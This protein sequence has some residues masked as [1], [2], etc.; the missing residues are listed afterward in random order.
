MKNRS[1]CCIQPAL[2]LVVLV[3]QSLALSA[4]EIH[5]VPLD[6]PDGQ[7]RAEFFLNAQG[8]PG[9]R[10]SRAGRPVLI[11]SRLGLI[12]EDADFSSALIWQEPSS[13][14][15]ILDTYELPG[16]KRLVNRYEANRRVFRLA[17]AKGGRID[18]TFQVSN[19][20]VAFRY[21]FPDASA[22]I[23]RIREE[24]TSFRFDPA[25]RAWLQPIAEA[26]TSWGKCNPSY[27]EY[28]ECD[29]PVGK[30]PATGVGWVY[31]A[32]YRAANSGDTWA[33]ISESGLDGQYCATR[34][35]ADS[36]NGEYRIGFPDSRETAF[37]GIVTPQSKLPWV[38]PWR[39]VALGS[40]ATVMESTLG[41]DVAPAPAVPYRVE[42][43][44]AAW[45]WPLLKDTNTTYDVQKSFV[46]YAARMGWRYCLVDALWDVQI[47]YERM[48]E[49]CRYAADKNVKIIV[50]YNSAGDWNETPQTPKNL[51]LSRASRLTE[52]RRIKD[53]GIS[54]LKIDFFGGDGQSMIAYYLDI[55]KDAEDF[56]F[57]INFH[58]CTLPR[59]W[60]RT[61]PH[62][63]TMEAIRGLEFVTFEQ[64]WADRAPV[65]MTMLPF[66]R[67]V[68]DPMDFT[69]MVLDSIPNINRHTSAAFELATAV[70]Y[71]SGVQHYAETPQGM[72]KMPEF[73]Q[74]FV[75]S[76][77]SVWEEVRFI[78]GHPGE[79]LVM[80]RKSGEQWFVAGISSAKQ[81]KTLQLDLS[82]LGELDAGE[83]ITDA[84]P[85][86][87]MRFAKV[88]CAT[89][90]NRRFTVTLRPNSGFVATF[91]A[92]KH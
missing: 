78:D 25:S 47:G 66:A 88:K 1:A 42:P 13:Q 39:V 34:L 72:A 86:D 63:V 79:Y 18:I 57:L 23:H 21:A 60:Q 5:T 44:K 8:S 55:L 53:I 33:L 77:P 73:V 32:L 80:A 40:L 89:D 81:E 70:L 75:R 19:D 26:K 20:G 6:S 14:S 36:S 87:G 35:R 22:E 92:R 9:Y 30:S 16:S 62:L 50:W 84:E 71:V 68:F 2:A 83:C 58:G 85:K 17:T 28:Y 76:I 51:M 10:I 49:L 61:Y 38:T 15:R 54:G 24:V 59:G 31:P 46:D 74:N 11:D 67:N 56:G 65:H 48:R 90:S 12:R 3:C 27:E 91:G 29:I 7:V 4:A 37:E 64:Q 43:G 41:T 82:R 52:F 69:P 45:S